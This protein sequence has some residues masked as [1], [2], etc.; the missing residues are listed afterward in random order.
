MLQVQTAKARRKQIAGHMHKLLGTDGVMMLP[1]AP[2]P[3]PKLN[4]PPAETDQFRTRL[5]SLT[6]IA[7]L[8]GL[9]QVCNTLYHMHVQYRNR[10]MSSNYFFRM[11]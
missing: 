10:H 1:S 4:T 9:P 2:G 11:L 7:G 8:A 6:C 5:L 3:A